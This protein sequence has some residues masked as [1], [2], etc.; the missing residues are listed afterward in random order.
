MHPHLIFVS[1]W[2]LREVD[3]LAKSW[4]GKRDKYEHFNCYVYE[5]FVNQLQMCLPGGVHIDLQVLIP[6]LVK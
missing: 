6:Y 5:I 4:T 1:D 3:I 2:E